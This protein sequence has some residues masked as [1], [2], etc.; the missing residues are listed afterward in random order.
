[1]RAPTPAQRI[2]AADV[3]KVTKPAGIRPTP[4]FKTVLGSEG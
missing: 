3:A 4:A 1:M 2:L